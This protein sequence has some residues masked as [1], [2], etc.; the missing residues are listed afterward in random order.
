[1]LADSKPRRT[2]VSRRDAEAKLVE[3]RNKFPGDLRNRLNS[4]QVAEE[5]CKCHPK[6]NAKA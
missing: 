1:M 6:G 4:P 3:C 5:D 2:E